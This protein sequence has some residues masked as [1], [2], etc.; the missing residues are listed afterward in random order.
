MNPGHESLAM[1]WTYKI[2]SVFHDDD[3]IL[4]TCF[5]EDEDDEDNKD[6]NNE[7]ETNDDEDEHNEENDDDDD[8]D[9]DVDVDVCA[10][11]CA[12]QWIISPSRDE[13]KKAV[14]RNSTRHIE[15][16]FAAKQ[17]SCRTFGEQIFTQ[18]LALNL[19]VSTFAP[20]P[21]TQPLQADRVG[22]QTF[23]IVDIGR[24]R[25]QD[26]PKFQLRIFNAKKTSMSFSRFFL[27]RY[28]HPRAFQP[29]PGKCRNSVPFLWMATGKRWF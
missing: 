27:W 19:G 7:D 22:F 3:I 12:F 4:F 1:F 9:D 16:T 18:H 25:I 2:E 20:L 24:W 15:P 6:D 26:S 13:N 8:D 28:W 5:H 29:I 11:K 21:S 23:P 14:W 17:N 10:F